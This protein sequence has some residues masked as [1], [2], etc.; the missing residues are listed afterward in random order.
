MAGKKINDESLRVQSVSGDNLLPTVD[1]L[2][3]N[4]PKVCTV[5]DIFLYLEAALGVNEIPEFS[6]QNNY[7]AP[8]LVKHNNVL[9]RF[10]AFK[11]AGVWDSS[12]VVQTSIFE[13]LQ[14]MRDGDNE[15]VNVTV[16]SG[17]NLLTVEGLTVTMT[18]N[19]TIVNQTTDASGNCS[20]TVTKG[21][22]YTLS[23]S[24]QQ[25][26]YHIA[27]KAFRAT[28]NERYVL[29]HFVPTV[30]TLT[31]YESV[32]VLLSRGD[33]QGTV[34]FVQADGNYVQY[35]IEDDNETH[36]VEVENG[37]ATFTVPI[38]KA[39]T[40]IFP[41]ISGF[42][43][44][45][46][47]QYTAAIEN[48]YLSGYY[49]WYIGDDSF[50]INCVDG[51]EYTI[52]AYDALSV[53]PTAVAIHV[54]PSQLLGKASGLN[55]GKLCD[56]YL[57][58]AFQ[59]ASKQILSA[60]V[61]ITDLP[62]I[63]GST[64]GQEGTDCHYDYTG[65][66]NTKKIMDFVQNNSG[67]TSTGG[68]YATEKQLTVYSKDGSG[69]VIS[70]TL[71]GFIGAFGQLWAIKSGLTSINAALALAGG[72][73]LNINSGDWWSSTQYNYN[74]MWRISGGNPSNYYYKNYNYTVLP[75]FA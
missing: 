37:W 12:K 8:D 10:I 1:P 27:P 22:Y 21:A 39:Y 47:M 49:A 31:G 30:E 56:F 58:V 4:V 34:P 40:I 9:Y 69:N 66:F 73:S 63:S 32:S 17:D 59:T 15:T 28:Y 51:V 19:G 48:R 20:F 24:D 41:Q 6:T 50:R 44:P 5:H 38:G 55:D 53:K 42:S 62:Q 43:Q 11:A 35:L 68:Q 65:T 3:P 14:A 36:Q 71:T 23:M 33:T 7:A 25:N 74:L 72:N 57:P 18:C 16:D 67:Y 54:M 70:Q 45:Q 26:Y 2:Q 29:F 52:E 75:L 13:E 61:L 60:N 64:S 46:N